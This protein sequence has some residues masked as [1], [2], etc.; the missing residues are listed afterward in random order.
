MI[1]TIT[2][3]NWKFE[4]GGYPYEFLISDF[5]FLVFMVRNNKRKN[6]RR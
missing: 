5:Q 4:I 3:E 1:F 6:G 2:T